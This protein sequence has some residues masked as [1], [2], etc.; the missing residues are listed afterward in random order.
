MSNYPVKARRSAVEP[1]T[2]ATP[3][4]VPARGEGDARASFRYA[5]ASISLEGG[6][7]RVKARHARWS[8]GK[9][10]SESFEGDIDPS[11]FKRAV[12]E[13][14]RQFLAQTALFWESFAAL[15]P[16]SGRRGGRD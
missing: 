3:D 11:V 12:E 5:Y 1:A 14:Q 7:A 2:R 9:L 4:V 10:E 16:F 15:L 13:A 8:A 6:K